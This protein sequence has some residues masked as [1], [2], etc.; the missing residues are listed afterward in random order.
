[1]VGFEKVLRAVKAIKDQI[2]Y[3]SQS[4]LNLARDHFSGDA[5]IFLKRGKNIAQ[6]YTRVFEKRNPQ[7]FCLRSANAREFYGQKLPQIYASFLG[8]KNIP[9]MREVR[10][11]WRRLIIDELIARVTHK[12]VPC[13]P[14]TRDYRPSVKSPAKR[15]KNFCEGTT[16]LMSR[17][18]RTLVKKVI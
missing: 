1:M 7:T 9:E 18:Y 5:C 3:R 2:Q 16:E 11:Y 12:V 8:K 17:D 15:V 6:I 4:L 10:A 14:L 13:T